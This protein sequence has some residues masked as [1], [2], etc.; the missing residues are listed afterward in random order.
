M[1]QTIIDNGRHYELESTSVE[2]GGE[3][4]GT[5]LWIPHEPDAPENL[6]MSSDV[7]GA[8]RDLK[9][10]AEVI[11]NPN[12][13]PAEARFPP[14]QW[15]RSQGSVGSCAGY[16]GAW[17]L[18]RCRVMAGM[19]YVPL[20]G[21]S[22]YSQTNGG[23]DQGSG[24]VNNI[25]AMVTTGVA[26]EGL[27]QPGRFYTESSLPAA[28][29]AERHRFKADEWYQVRTEIELAIAVASGFIIGVACHVGGG[30]RRFDG[31]LLIG[32]NGPGN[33]AT[34][35]D[36]VRLKGGKPQ[37]RMVNSHGLSWGKDGVAWV[38]WDRTFSGPIRNHVFYAMRSAKSDPKA[39]NPP[40]VLA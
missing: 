2:V 22:L 10:V 20:S 32:N 38:D 35:V 8:V 13:T 23:R 3:Q 26:P 11:S 40:K 18:A 29:K 34:I 16:A 15:T 24:L 12:R 36:D 7:A 6:L 30:W 31:D 33:H 39:T 14:K 21:E 17:T 9:D 5:G 1:S 27:N 28:A 25:K 4:F 37:F 19:D